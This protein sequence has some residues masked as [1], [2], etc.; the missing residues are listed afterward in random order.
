MGGPVVR[1]SRRGG[2]DL[3]KGQS[4]A[5]LLVY[6]DNESLMATRHQAPGPIVWST[7]TC[8][9]MMTLEC[10]NKTS[11]RP[12]SC[13]RVRPHP[14][15]YIITPARAVTR[16]Q[17]CPS[18]PATAEPVCAGRGAAA[19]ASSSQTSAELGH[20]MVGREPAEDGSTAHTDNSFCHLLSWSF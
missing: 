9:M 20:V 6:D 16:P 17:R 5:R 1:L 15:V 13:G 3:V 7:A 10:R 4:A 2:G 18:P 8:W 12:G 14:M 19:A 11:P